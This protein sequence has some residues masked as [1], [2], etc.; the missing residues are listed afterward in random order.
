VYPYL[1][2]G[3]P[4]NRVD[5]VWSTDITY[6]PLQDG[7]V[8]LCAVIDWHSRYVISWSVSCSMDGLWCRSVLQEALMQGRPEVFNTDKG[9]QFTSPDYVKEL[10]SREIKV[11]MN[12]RGR[13]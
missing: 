13:A 6:I 3:V 8:Y 11:N 2:R 4:V 12:A 1:L 7:Y 10:T 9:S 5:H